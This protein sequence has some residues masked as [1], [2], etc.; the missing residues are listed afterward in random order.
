M[1]TLEQGARGLSVRSL[2]RELNK[3]GSKI[4]VDGNFGPLTEKA[5]KE[6]QLREGLTP[7]GVVGPNTWDKLLD[8]SRT[9]QPEVL[10]E[11]PQQARFGDWRDTALQVSDGDRAFQAMMAFVRRWEG[12]Y[13]VDHAGPTNYG[14]TQPF[15]EQYLKDQNRSTLFGRSVAR[16]T[17]PE[18]IEIYHRQIWEKAGVGEVAR[19]SAAAGILEDRLTADNSTIPLAIVL[20][21][22]A[23]N[24][25]PG[26]ASK[27]M[28][29]AFKA[30]GINEGDVG[31]CADAAAR[32]GAV[33]DVLHTY[34]ELEER[35]YRDLGAKPKYE[36]FLAG[37]LNRHNSL[38]AQLATPLEDGIP[39]G[40][41][42]EN[43]R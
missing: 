22:G 41:L 28:L 19:G 33:K 11:S 35:H 9:P 39:S 3:E 18:A 25:G 37:W 1:P 8:D 20:G 36:K 32:R 7:D 14:I 29:Q 17:E 23:I 21:N 15:Y 4:T 5:V 38:K 10:R 30:S 43:I 27:F 34:L 42:N 26:R 40:L 24:Y 31:A 13:T 2:Q 12:K 16:L 6:F